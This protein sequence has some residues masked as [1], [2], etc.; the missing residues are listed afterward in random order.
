[1]CRVCYNKWLRHTNPDYRKQ[2]NAA[3]RR[4][5]KVNPKVKRQAKSRSI[6]HRYGITLDEYEAMLVKQNNRCYMC[7]HMF[8]S[9]K[10]THLDH[11]HRT[12]A[13]RRMLCSRCNHIVGYVE[14]YADRI[15]KAKKYLKEFE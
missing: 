9:S 2:V 12:G 14:N 8:T 4:L 13:I 15:D 5:A 1:M 11:N 3:W 7:Q 10:S 6:K